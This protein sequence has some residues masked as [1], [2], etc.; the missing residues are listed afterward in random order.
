M[1]SVPFLSSSTGDPINTRRFCAIQT[2]QGV[3]PAEADY[4][5]FLSNA[6]AFGI[7][8]QSVTP[9]L[10]STSAEQLPDLVGKITIDPTTLALGDADPENKVLMRSA[11]NLFRFYTQTAI[12]GSRERWEYFLAGVTAG[13]PFLA[14]LNDNDVLPR[15]RFIDCL[16]NSLEN[17]ATAGSDRGRAH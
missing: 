2:T 10:L 13:A 11:S 14:F 16:V 12:G 17:A 7:A 4:V 15:Q 1:P 8:A 5:E 3:P 6:G 9:H